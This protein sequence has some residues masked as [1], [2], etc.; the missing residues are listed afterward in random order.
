[1]RLIV[2][3]TLTF[4]FF[5][6]L[7][8][9]ATGYINDEFEITMRSG[10][11]TRHSIVRMLPTVHVVKVGGRSVIEGG[12]DRCYAGGCGPACRGVFH[13]AIGRAVDG[14]AQCHRT[15]ASCDRD[16]GI[17]FGHLHRQNRNTDSK[18]NVGRNGHDS[19]VHFH[20]WWHR[21]RTSR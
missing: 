10:E 20:G 3:I 9:G 21:L 16:A 2:V 14:Q 17:R 1:M 13:S 4:S 12:R 11:S 5:S 15:K 7:A 18:R 19:R 8:L 6:P